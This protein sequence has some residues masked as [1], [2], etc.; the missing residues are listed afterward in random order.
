VI[1]VDADMRRPNVHISSASNDYGLSDIFRE[2]GVDDAIK[3]WQD[4]QVSVIT[5]WQYTAEFI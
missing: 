3:E 2:L 4:G 5:A 1:V